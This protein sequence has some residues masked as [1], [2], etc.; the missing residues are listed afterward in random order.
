MNRVF[1][2]AFICA[3]L[4]VCSQRPAS[5]M[6]EFCPAHLQYE[7]VGS[8][9]SLIRQQSARDATGKSAEQVSSLYGLE[10]T[11]FGPRAVTHAM[12]TFDTSGG[13]YIVDVPSLTLVEKDRHYT[14]PSSKF[15]LQDYVSPVFYVHFPQA[16]AVNHGWVS[17][18]ATHGDSQFD[19]DAQGTVRCDPVPRSTRT[20]AVT[21]FNRRS[22]DSPG[23]SLYRLGPNDADPLSRPPQP[24]SAVLPA[25]TAAPP[26]PSCAKP[27]EFAL[28]T[29]AQT[30]DYPS[31]M[32]GRFGFTT[33]EVALG[34]DGKLA[35]AWIWGP[36]G[37]T[38]FDAVS[39]QA[40][41]R[42]TYSAGRAYCKPAPGYYF[43]RVT[44]D[45]DR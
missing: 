44:F 37:H 23:Q 1:A 9:A 32:R 43:F 28:V 10:L 7:R 26:Y 41:Q 39:L 18:A 38:E 45:P 16:V 35:D 4:F 3:A 21:S 17:S 40:A 22:S 19:W 2:A 6:V 33:V 25:K 15:T 29:H 30:P 5:A 27:F 11:A 24:A 34:A 14:G 42:S 12:L 13:W 8:G 31:S 20:I 36:S